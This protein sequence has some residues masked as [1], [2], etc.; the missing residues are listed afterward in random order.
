MKTQKS[1]SKL[2]ISESPLFSMTVSPLLSKLSLKHQKDT[3]YVKN[4][5]GGKFLMQ[6]N[7]QKKNVTEEVFENTVRF[8]RPQ[9]ELYFKICLY[10]LKKP[11]H[12]EFCHLF[13]YQ[14]ITISS[15]TISVT[16][17]LISK[18]KL[19]QKL[20]EIYKNWL[21]SM[22]FI[23]QQEQNI[24]NALGTAGYAHKIISAP[25]VK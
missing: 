5:Q 21:F 1:I 22:C 12:T 14:T 20:T 23:S 16:S 24:L 4:K 2:Y 13:R 7:M 19:D 15:G 8:Y 3:Y 17:S 11:N 25:W 10:G 18:K 6:K 9:L